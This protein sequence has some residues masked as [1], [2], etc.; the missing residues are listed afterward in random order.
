MDAPYS[1]EV[2]HLTISLR[3]VVALEDVSLRVRPGEIHALLGTD[4]AGKTTLLKILG[5]LY[6]ASTYRGEIRLAGQPVTLR[7]PR[8]AIERGVAVVSRRPSVFGS[9]SVAENIVMGQWQT[10]HG[11]LIN[12]QAIL[13]QADAT[14]KRLGVTLE[15]DARADRL[16]PTQKRVV[17]LARALNVNPRLVVL[18]EPAAYATSPAAMSQLLRIARLL[19]SQDI[20]ILYLTRT[21]S[22]AMQIADRVTVLRDGITGRTFERV[23]FDATALTVEMASQHPER[24]AGM[25]DETEQPSG[26]LGSLRSIFSFGSRR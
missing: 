1:L 14:L 5:G 2:S 3:S 4:G 8:D 23:D 11:F 6:P 17:V 22:E 9:L 7:S 13:R 20:A 16:D 26:L 18:D 24:G 25:D 15:L 19:A 12:R 10:Q 21:P